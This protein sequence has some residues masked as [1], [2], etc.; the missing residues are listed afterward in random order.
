MKKIYFFIIVFFCLLDFNT[1]ADTDY[2]NDYTLI[3][4]ETWSDSTWIPFDSK[5]PYKTLN[6]WIEKTINYINTY[7]NTWPVWTQSWMTFNIKVKCSLMKIG[8]TSTSLNFDWYTY[9]NFLKIE[10][11]WDNWL[12]INDITFDIPHGKWNIIFYNAKFLSNSLNWKYFTYTPLPR[13]PYTFTPL[14]M[15]YWII[16]ENSYIKLNPWSHIGLTYTSSFYLYWNQNVYHYNPFQYIKNSTIDIEVNWNYNFITPMLV[17]D[18]KINFINNYSTWTYD[19]KFMEM[20]N[21]F[22]WYDFDF[23]TLLSNE[24]DM[25]WNNFSTENTKNV[26]YINNK[27]SKFNNLYLWQ[28]DIN[29]KYWI[30]INNLFE[31]TNTIDISKNRNIINNVF[32]WTYTDTYDIRNLRKNYSINNLWTKW[33]GW[34]FQKLHATDLFKLNYSSTSLYKEITWNDVPSINNTVYAIFSW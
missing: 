12:T 26:S 25:W 30:F 19:I 7:V 32:S 34:V 15:N 4:C 24:I 17:K 6:E 27:F 31:N 16:I 11:I 5:T 23:F 33:V 10:W 14:Y 1:F 20:W 22:W 13:V 21:Y 2:Q 3:D 28:N 8:T 9:K 29:L 18:S